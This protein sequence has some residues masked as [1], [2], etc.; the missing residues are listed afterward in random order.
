MSWLE[1]ESVTRCFLQCVC[2]S[3]GPYYMPNW[4]CLMRAGM[5]STTCCLAVVRGA[6]MVAM[7][8]VVGLRYVSL[9]L[10]Q[11]LT[12][13]WHS[14]CGVSHVLG[15]QGNSR[16]VYFQLR[17]SANFGWGT[18]IRAKERQGGLMRADKLITP[19]KAVVVTWS[20]TASLPAIHSVPR[21][22]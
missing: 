3:R 9:V 2:H 14:R 7:V 13:L 4:M 22:E 1:L 6:S 12:G 11:A 20:I 19:H 21:L 17:A 5:R 16:V 10:S 8:V 15:E 18:Q